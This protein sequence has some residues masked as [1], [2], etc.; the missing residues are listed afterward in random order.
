VDIKNNPKLIKAAGDET[1]LATWVK[2][3][4]DTLKD[5]QGTPLPAESIPAKQAAKQGLFELMARGTDSYEVSRVILVERLI[6]PLSRLHQLTI[7]S[8]PVFYSTAAL[9]NNYGVPAALA[10]SLPPNPSDKPSNTEWGWKERENEEDVTP[11]YN[12]A[13]GVRMWVFA[14]WSTL[15]YDYV[16]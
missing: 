5:P 8:V 10:A 16:Q 6:K 11:V 3:C 4:K 1:T 9:K 15:M 7:W 13:E 14:A 12:K 2:Q